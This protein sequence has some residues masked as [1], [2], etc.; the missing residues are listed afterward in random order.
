MEDP[1]PM[2]IDVERPVNRDEFGQHE[3]PSNH[4]PLLTL[5]RQEYD[6]RAGNHRNDPAVLMAHRSSVVEP[7][8]YSNTS[9]GGHGEGRGDGRGDGRGGS[10]G[11]APWARSRTKRVVDLVAG[12]V[13]SLVT[14]PI[15]LVLCVGSAVAFRTWPLFRHP[16]LGRGGRSFAFVKVRSLPVAVPSDIDKYELRDQPSSRWGRF[17]RGRHLDEFPQCWLL[18][19][20]R[21]SLV[22]PR[23]EMPALS[24]TYDPAFVAARLQIRPGITGPWQISPDSAGL[25]GESPQYDLW[26]LAN[27]RPTLDLWLLWRTFL[28]LFG[29]RHRVLGEYPRR[30]V[31]T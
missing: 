13:L 1:I 25:I 5:A 16:R 29:G 19:S 22:G 8:D 31:A 14:F 20:G 21:M 3:R 28:G 17:I 4:E 24:A 12:V 11:V 27:A 10:S 2:R 9:P 30:F 18:V 7:R 23:P 6:L 15:V 26:Y